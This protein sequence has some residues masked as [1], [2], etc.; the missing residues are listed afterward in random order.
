MTRSVRGILVRPNDLAHVKDYWP[1]E[2]RELLLREGFQVSKSRFIGP[3]KWKASAL[4][5]GIELFVVKG[6]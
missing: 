6:S 5:P 1:C 2:L 4:A 3:N